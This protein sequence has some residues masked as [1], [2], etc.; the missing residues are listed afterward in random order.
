M[1]YQPKDKVIF[2]GDLADPQSKSVATVIKSNR[3][4]TDTDKGTFFTAYLFP[5]SVELE[6]DNIIIHRAKLKKTF[7]DSMSLIYQLNNKISR[8]E[9]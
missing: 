5:A 9:V 7:D 6:L 3:D 2:Y 1:I 8:G 4:T